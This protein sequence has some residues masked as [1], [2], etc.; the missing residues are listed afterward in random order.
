M[1]LNYYIYLYSK[2]LNKFFDKRKPIERRIIIVLIDISIILSI[3]VFFN[4]TIYN[5]AILFEKPTK[6]ILFLISFTI[7]SIVF[8]YFTGQYKGLSK[9]INSYSFYYIFFRNLGL[10][11]LLL[12]FSKIFSISFINLSNIFYL[13]IFLTSL[14]YSIRSIFKDFLTDLFLIKNKNIKNIV[15]YGAG[16]SGAR[17]AESLRSSNE[18]KIL[19]FVDDCPDLW[20][21]SINDVSIY[22]PIELKNK[23]YGVDEIYIALPNIKKSKK[24]EILNKLDFLN[25]KILDVASPKE[26]SENT[27]NVDSLRPISIDQLLG[28][29]VVPPNKYLLNKS[30]AKKNVCITGAGGSIGSELCKQIVK[31]NPSSLIIF[32]RSELAL[33]QIEKDLKINLKS[34]V[35]VIPIMG[36]ATDQILIENIIQKYK[37]DVIFH[38]AAYKHVPLVEANPITGLI[39]NLKSTYSICKAAEKFNIQ[40]VTLISTDKAVRPTNVMGCSKRLSEIV[41]QSFAK[42]TQSTIFAIVRFGNV[43]DSSGSVVPLFREQIKRGGPITLTHP[44]VIR[45]FMTKSEA[46]QLVMQASVLADGGEVFLLDMGDPVLI[47]DLAAQMIRLSGLTIK[48][49]NNPEG[50]IEIVT[51]GLRPGEKLFEELL[52]DAKSIPTIHPLIFKAKE[53]SLSAEWC[54]DKI[55]L[56]E[57]KLLNYEY[58][59]SLKIIKELVPEWKEYK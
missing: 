2:R 35:T 46:V 59:E 54:I 52:I 41:F 55:E 39:N 43:L 5:N 50:D 32:E 23:R 44:Q 1:D 7:V 36:C 48:D 27:L 56:L 15:I 26:I 33:Y 31:L 12:I 29:D 37:V 51:T 40:N 4:F 57:K 47:K 22:N 45:F 30:I 10:C 18:Y 9:F 17:L 42:Q 11:F 53:K 25:V 8:Y 49:E 20:N 34:K 14:T 58:S 38:S 19:F 16:I 28:R 6:N 13:L 24:K 21:R 3:F